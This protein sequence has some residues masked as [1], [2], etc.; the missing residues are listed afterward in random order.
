MKAGEKDSPNQSRGSG[1][2]QLFKMQVLKN[3]QEPFWE[4]TL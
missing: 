4:K 2:S 3:C 1:S